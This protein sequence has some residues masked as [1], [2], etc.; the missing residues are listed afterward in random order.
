MNKWK[1]TSIAF[2]VRK[3]GSLLNPPKFVSIFTGI[4]SK[5]FLLSQVTKNNDAERK[6]YDIIKSHKI[7][8]CRRYLFPYNLLYCPRVSVLKFTAKMIIPVAHNVLLHT[9]IVPSCKQYKLLRST[10]RHLFYYGGLRGN[11]SWLRNYSVWF[12]PPIKFYHWAIL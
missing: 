11:T 4:L 1:N 9:Y 5:S 8:K 12:R 6:D 7:M 10:C 2:T 3:C